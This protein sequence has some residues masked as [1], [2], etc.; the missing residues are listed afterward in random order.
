MIQTIEYVDEE[1]F[2]YEEFTTNLIPTTMEETTT[3]EE[4][5]TTT[6]HPH[7]N[8]LPWAFV[9]FFNITEEIKYDYHVEHLMFEGKIIL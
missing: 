1:E 7:S 6:E 2:E 8:P 5:T 3:T 4:P 9:D